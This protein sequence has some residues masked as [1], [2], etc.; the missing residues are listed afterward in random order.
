MLS[1]K[2]SKC[3]EVKFISEF[4][5]SKR[6]SSGYRSWCKGCVSEQR[7]I[8]RV[9]HKKEIAEY[10]KAWN[11]ANRERN[12]IVHALYYQ[13]NREKCCARSREYYH[14]NKEQEAARSKTY[15]LLHNRRVYFRKWRKDNPDKA[16]A[17]RRNRRA[18]KNSAPGYATGEQ[19]SWR[20]EVHGN[21][22]YICGAPAEATDHV[23]PLDK[24]GSDWPANLRPICRRCNSV[25]GPKWPYD[26]EAARQEAGYYD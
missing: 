8:H 9:T 10:R 2:C 23:I 25:K 22:C 4:N 1:K 5:I 17:K 26:I 14:A 7:K 21:K 11:A 15:R 20:W 13:S 24:G 3:G 12:A 18:R 6:S 16:R 19:E